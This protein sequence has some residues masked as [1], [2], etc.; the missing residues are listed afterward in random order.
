MLWVLTVVCFQFMG[1]YWLRHIRPDFTEEFAASV[2]EGVNALFKM[3]AGINTDD[4]SNFARERMRLPIKMKGCELR[5]SR[6][7][8]FG[9]FLG[10][11]VQSTL[12]LVHYTDSKNCLH[13]GRLNTPPHHQL[14][15]GRKLRSPYHLTMGDAPV[16]G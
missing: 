13:R 2:D 5:D 11:M 7:R 8:R 16:T 9:Q 12:P 10:A 1:D 15:W 6:D 3:C 14:L 4:W